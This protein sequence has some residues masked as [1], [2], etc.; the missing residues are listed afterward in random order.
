M[1]IT[2]RPPLSQKLL[3]MIERA[4]TMHGFIQTTVPDGFTGDTDEIIL[5]AALYSL[6][7]EHHSALLYLLRAGQFDGSAFALARPL[8]D[9]AYR[10]H[11]IYSCAKPEIIRRIRKG[12]NCYPGLQNMAEE[13]EK[14]L[15]T[16]GFFM[17]VIPYI[18]ALHGFTHG[19]LEQLSRRFDQEGNIRPTY[20][21]PDKQE[22][23]NFTTAHLTA[24]AIAWC[25]LTSKVFDSTE[26]RSMLI[27]AKHSEL[28]GPM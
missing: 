16:D 27:S 15:R 7:E 10:A 20:I 19:G 14:K 17:T 21:D 6:V 18:M 22:L 5:M 28:Y 23:I 8:I 1:P 9:A 26:P 2:P 12:E 3:Q 4:E 24:L 25:Q 13:V 11:W